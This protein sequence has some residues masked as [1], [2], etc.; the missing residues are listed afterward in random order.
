MGNILGE[1]KALNLIAR[2][3]ETGLPSRKTKKLLTFSNT[4][5]GN[6]SLATVT[7]VVEI[8][9]L[10]VCKTSL[11][12][13]AA[14]TLSVGVTA[15]ATSIITT[16]GGSGI[17][18][19]EIW[20]DASPDAKIEALTVLNKYITSDDIICAVASGTGIAS[21]AI[22]FTILWSPLTED[23]EVTAA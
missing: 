7:G 8:S 14:T 2:A 6:Q 12:C 9:V 1:S 19:E 17:A 20:H 21:G 23:G 5:T 13:H 10:A 22:E 11:V 3:I 15:A 18:A 16:T 4:G